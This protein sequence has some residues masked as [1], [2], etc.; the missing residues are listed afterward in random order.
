M[1]AV[2]EY[3]EQWEEENFMR[4]LNASIMTFNFFRK[5]GKRLSTVLNILLFIGYQAVKGLFMIVKLLFLTESSIQKI[6]RD[7]TWIFR[8]IK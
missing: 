3:R 7:E 1:K 6:E 5:A 4:L 8:Q 2:K